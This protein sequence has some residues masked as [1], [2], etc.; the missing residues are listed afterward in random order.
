MRWRASRPAV[1]RDPLGG[2][3]VHRDID[4]L[5]RRL[6]HS[7]PGVAIE[8]LKVSHPGADDDG[9]WFVIHP[10]GR[11]EAQSESS[12]GALPFLVESDAAPPPVT[13]H[14]IAEAVALVAARLGLPAR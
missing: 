7:S 13:A 9:V 6:R 11:G 1:K 14:T 4:E 3:N 10:G 12:T 2:C 5:S 8:Q